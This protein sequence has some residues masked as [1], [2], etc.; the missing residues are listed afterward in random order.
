M[1]KILELKEKRARLVK[2]AREL[3]E[4]PNFNTEDSTQYDKLMQ[5]VDNLKTQVDRE[6]RLFAL[7]AETAG[8]SNGNDYRANPSNDTTNRPKFEARGLNDLAEDEKLAPRLA[9]RE[10]SDYNMAIRK[11][12]RG[13]NLNEKEQRA[14]SAGNDAQAG[15]LTV[16]NRMLDG[17]IKNVDNA[18]FMRRLSTVIRLTDAQSLGSVTLTSDPAAPSWTGE[19]DAVTYDDDLA[20]GKRELWPRMLQ[21]GIKISRRLLQL[22]PSAENLVVERFSYKFAV[23]QESTFMTGTGSGQPLG[24]FTASTNGV[25]TGRDV[26]TD[27]TTTAITAD[28]LRNVKYTLKDQY[29]PDAV[30]IFHRDA[31]KMISKLKDGEGQYLW[32]PGITAND[33][34]SLLGAPVYSSEYAPNTFTTGLYVGMYCV[35]RHYWIAEVSSAFELQRLNEKYAETNQIAF[36]MRMWLDGAPVLEEAFVRV[37]L[38]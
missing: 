9:S 24:I 15:Y 33:P 6:E 28:N 11:S 25:S 19:N 27:N 8:A 36:I 23:T 12:I 34:D 4:R 14:L 29:R 7:E 20:F 1:S 37:K 2:E 5:E 18:V 26:S 32:Q 38:A 17:L 3:N 13:Q 21:K 10:S 30:W 16:S 31:V 35:P 22:A